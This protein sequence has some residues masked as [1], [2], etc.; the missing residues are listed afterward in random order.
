MLPHG[1]F[2]HCVKMASLLVSRISLPSGANVHAV[3]ELLNIVC[4]N[5]G[6]HENDEYIMTKASGQIVNTYLVSLEKP[7]YSILKLTQ[8][9][10][11]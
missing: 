9:S 1:V 2:I 10:L 4:R 8:L 11:P 3:C 6:K 5:T 7:L